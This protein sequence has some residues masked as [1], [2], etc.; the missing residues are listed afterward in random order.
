MRPQLKPALPRLWRDP[1]TLQLGLDPQRARLLSGVDVADLAVLDLLDGRRPVDGVVELARRRGHDAARARELVDVLLD[2]AALDDAGAGT[3]GSSL[4]PDLLSLSLLHPRPGA[5]ARLMQARHAATVE[6]LGAGRVGATVATLLAASGIGHLDVDDDGPLRTAD[7]APGGLRT[8]GGTVCH[9]GRRDQPAAEHGDHAPGPAGRPARGL[10][11]GADHRPAG[12]RA[13]QPNSRPAAPAR[14]GPGDHC[15]RRP[16]RPPG[17]D[18]LLPLRR[19]GPWRPRSRLAVVVGP[20][21]R[22]GPPRRGVRRRA[23]DPRGIAGRRAA[24]PVPRRPGIPAPSAR[25]GAGDRAGRPLPATTH[26]AALPGVRLR[27]RR[28]TRGAG[29]ALTAAAA[30][31]RSQQE[32]IRPP[33]IARTARGTAA[34][35][36]WPRPRC[37]LR[38][39]PRRSPTAPASAPR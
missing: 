16:A 8:A 31:Y 3:A 29:A 22:F 6:V 20:A 27:R 15:R 12:T 28:L 26:G 24:A 33:A 30:R 2:A 4:E 32:P 10:G 21:A 39:A 35:R 13:A 36:G 9:P 17:P 11:A 7:V 37:S 25:R 34:R 1:T 5:A 18:A 38:A 14:P 19:A 23:R